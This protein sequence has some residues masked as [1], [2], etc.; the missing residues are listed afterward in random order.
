MFGPQPDGGRPPRVIGSC[1]STYQA[2]ALKPLAA[3]VMAFNH[4]RSQGPMMRVTKRTLPVPKMLCS[5]ST[6]TVVATKIMEA[7][8]HLLNKIM[9]GQ[10]SSFLSTRF[11]P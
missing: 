1:P 2:K 5:F 3:A 10:A 7:N 4:G 9:G 11:I 6:R 8:K